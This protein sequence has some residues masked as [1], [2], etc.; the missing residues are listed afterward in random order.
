MVWDMSNLFFVLSAPRG[1]VR[2]IAVAAATVAVMTACSTRDRPS[3]PDPAEGPTVRK[4]VIA[5]VEFSAGLQF[6]EPPGSTA[7]PAPQIKDPDAVEASFLDWSPDGRYLAYV[8]GDF[9]RRHS[10]I[11]LLDVETGETQRLSSGSLDASPV[12]SP[13]GHRIAFFRFSRGAGA[14]WVMDKDGSHARAVTSPGAR[15]WEPFRDPNVF[16][17]PEVIDPGTVVRAI[18]WSPDSERIAFTIDPFGGHPE[19]RIVP[20]DGEA[21]PTIL[22]GSYPTWSPDGTRLCLAQRTPLG[23][24]LVTISPDGTDQDVITE[25]SATHTM[26]RWSPDGASILYV[27][28]EEGP[29]G[30][31][32]LWVIGSHGSEPRQ[33]TSDAT[34]LSGHNPWQLY[35]SWSPDGSMIVYL[36]QIFG[37]GAVDEWVNIVSPNGGPTET[38]THSESDWPAWQPIPV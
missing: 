6:V 26:P 29:P 2:H 21:E 7:S 34:E 18:A 3:G 25:G 17:T 4:G 19:V 24:R 38:L 5:Y 10:S 16:P 36:D 27:S 8:D 15:P 32:E 11:A 30:K 13:Y 35:P 37:G 9:F 22:E 1:W 28:D 33:V 14:L 20:L 31:L 23:T 12:W